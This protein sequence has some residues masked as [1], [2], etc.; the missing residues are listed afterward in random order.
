[1][2]RLGKIASDEIA[3]YD[4]NQIDKIIRN[5][6]KVAKANAVLLAKMAVEE[7]GFGNYKDKT[8]KSHMA[9]VMLYEEI[10]DIKTIG[11]IS[12]DKVNEVIKI[13]EPIGLLLGIIPSTNPTSTAIFKCI[14]A[15]KSRNA[16]IFSPHPSACKCTSKATELMLEAALEAGAPKNII[17][18]L[19]T[20]SMQATDTLMKADEVS[21]IIATG[22]HGMVKAAYGSGTPAIGVGAGNSPVFI[23]KTANIKKAISDIMI[24]KTFDYGT[25][26][27]SEQSS[28][29][30]WNNAKKMK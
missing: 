2:A 12:E 20:L 7:T 29:S 25:V 3:T 18:C 14:I 16:I 21:M 27:A 30:L 9:S 4:E 22:G 10:K 5:M 17:S 19:K 13:A 1:M 23:E 8:Y 24:S 28:Q 11:V 15:I 26:C 6:V